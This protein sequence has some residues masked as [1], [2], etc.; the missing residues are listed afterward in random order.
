MSVSLITGI[1]EKVNPSRLTTPKGECVCVL[2]FAKACVYFISYCV[3][4]CFIFLFVVWCEKV[5]MCVCGG[6][7]GA[8]QA[9]GRN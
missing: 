3:F 4:A 7:G 8:V 5:C 1:G 6:K 2:V 9:W